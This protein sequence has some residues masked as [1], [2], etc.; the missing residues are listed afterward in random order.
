MGRKQPNPPPPDISLK[1]GPPPL[2]HGKKEHKFTIHLSGESLTVL[3]PD[4]FG[5][6]ELADLIEEA[7]KKW[8][9]SN[10]QNGI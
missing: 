2:P 5:V 8:I 6:V 7:V 10:A 3:V 9:E 1:P 4:G